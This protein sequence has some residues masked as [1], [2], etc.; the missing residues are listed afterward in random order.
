[1]L[2]FIL[3]EAKETIYDFLQGT[4]IA[5]SFCYDIISIQMTQYYGLNVKLFNSKFNKLK[6]VIK[7]MLLK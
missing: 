1:M 3:A 4:S 2:F 6:S 7:K 5:N